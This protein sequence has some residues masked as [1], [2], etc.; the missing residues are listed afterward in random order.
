MF[1]EKSADL[2]KKRSIK[3]V[4]SNKKSPAIN[5]TVNQT[6]IQ[7]NSIENESFPISILK[8][9]ILAPLESIIKYLR[10]NKK[11][12]YKQISSLI[13]RNPKSL[14]T[15]YAIAKRKSPEKFVF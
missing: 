10:E 1:E 4:T 7:T 2:D 8:N 15:T 3:I 6:I 13:A 5:P 9:D 14:A 12:T 11:L